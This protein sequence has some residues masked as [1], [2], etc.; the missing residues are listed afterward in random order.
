[1]TRKSVRRCHFSL[2]AL[3]L[4]KPPPHPFPPFINGTHS[5][6][7]PNC[8]QLTLFDDEYGWVEK[9]KPTNKHNPFLLLTILTWCSL[10]FYFHFDFASWSRVWN[11][12]FVAA[13]AIWVAIK[14]IMDQI[15]SKRMPYMTRW[16]FFGIGL[17][18]SSLR[19]YVSQWHRYSEKLKSNKIAVVSWW[20]ID[21]FLLWK[22]ARSTQQE[23][24]R[25]GL[26]RWSEKRENNG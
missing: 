11:I 22:R 16:K 21:R 26:E 7:Y 1:M 14:I 4:R 8:P 15:D 20:S 19:S 3:F 12:L 25:G 9:K 18:K 13:E 23:R 24:R 2:C 10:Y 5:V 6:K 17:S